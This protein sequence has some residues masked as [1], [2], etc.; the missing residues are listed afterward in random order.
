MTELISRPPTTDETRTT[1]HGEWHQLVRDLRGPAESLRH[2]IP[3]AWRGFVELHEASLADGALPRRAKE[4]IALALA[5][6]RGCDECIGYH[7]REAA[8][9]GANPHEV[10]EALAV[11]LFMSG[12]PA[13]V[14]GPKAWT[15]YREFSGTAFGRR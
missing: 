6:S 8:R 3:D 7:A 4:L 9:A 14:H 1:G 15:A 5:V 13:S 11:T 12:A 2:H 10:A